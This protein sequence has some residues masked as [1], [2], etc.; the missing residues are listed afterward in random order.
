MS[1]ALRT[2][3]RRATVARPSVSFSTALGATRG[4][5]TLPELDYDFGALEPY[6][7]GTINEVR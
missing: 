3:L 5:A 6:I 2:A 7:S 4:K 1:F